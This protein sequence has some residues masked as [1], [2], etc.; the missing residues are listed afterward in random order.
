MLWCQ[1]DLLIAI[2]ILFFNFTEN[3]KSSENDYVTHVVEN[4]SSENQKKNSIIDGGKDLS[5]YKIISFRLHNWNWLFV[6]EAKDPDSKPT[7]NQDQPSKSEV[8]IDGNIAYLI[9]VMTCY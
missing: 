5:K 7:L 1:Q 6:T 4:N 9:L 8:N 2:K 3:F